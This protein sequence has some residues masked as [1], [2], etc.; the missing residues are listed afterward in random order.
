VAISERQSFLVLLQVTAQENEQ[1]NLCDFHR[2]KK[3]DVYVNLIASWVEKGTWDGQFLHP[4]GIAVDSEG[5]VFV[6]DEEQDV[7]R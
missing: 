5:N 6:T 2:V 7:V 3:F 4:H 1:L